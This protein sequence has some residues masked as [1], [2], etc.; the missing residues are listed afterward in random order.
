M[1]RR[2]FIRSVRVEIVR[3]ATRDGQAYCEAPGCGGLAKRF[4]IHHLKMDAMEIDKSRKLTAK[5]GALWCIP[6]HDKETSAQA[7]ILAQA[8]AREASHLRAAPPPEHPMRSRG[9]STKQREP[10]LSLTP[11]RLYVQERT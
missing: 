11:R 9:F 8:R 2:N 10:K 7:P 4:E 1:T 6:C 5:D 3:R